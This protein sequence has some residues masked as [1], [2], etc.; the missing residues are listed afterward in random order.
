LRWRFDHYPLTPLPVRSLSN[1]AHIHRLIVTGVV[2]NQARNRRG[3][4]VFYLL[5][6]LAHGR[7]AEIHQPDRDGRRP[8]PSSVEAS[9]DS[10]RHQLTRPLLDLAPPG[11]S[12][13]GLFHR[14][15]Y[16][17]RASKQ[18]LR[19]NLRL[20]VQ[21]HVQQGT[22]DFNLAAVVIDKAQFPKFVH[23]KTDARSRRADHLREGL[24][25]DFC[26]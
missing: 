6:S 10:R 2:G 12:R 1:I 8:S 26:Y 22:V 4:A 23:E 9:P 20:I 5:D 21:N 15:K 17:V 18:Q 24:L 3:P 7:R 13:R 16:S 19:S 14:P 11:R 25:A